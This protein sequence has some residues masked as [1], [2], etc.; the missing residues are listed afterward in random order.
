MVEP[1]TARPMNFSSIRIQFLFIPGGKSC[2]YTVE[3]L[4]SG[5]MTGCHWPD[6]KKS[7]IIEDDLLMSLYVYVKII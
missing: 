7:R 4:L 1:Y 6:N 2:C 5:L 3:C